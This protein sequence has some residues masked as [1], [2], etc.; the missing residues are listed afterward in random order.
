MRF[1][2]LCDVDYAGTAAEDIRNVPTESM[3]ECMRNCAGTWGCTGCGWGPMHVGEGPP[4]FRCWMKGD[5]GGTPVSREGW[6]FA[7]MQ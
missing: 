1:L 7:V 4:D 3:A 5:L 2:R 6:E